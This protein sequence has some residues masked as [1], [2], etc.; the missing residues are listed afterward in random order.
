MTDKNLDNFI[1]KFYENECAIDIE[2]FEIS[3]YFNHLK[4]MGDILLLCKLFL[5][6]M[7]ITIRYNG[8]E[9]IIKNTTDLIEFLY[10]FIK[11]TIPKLSKIKH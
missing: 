7:D 1:V 11:S 4:F 10:D 6:S 2:I 9:Y 8:K 5:N 3:N